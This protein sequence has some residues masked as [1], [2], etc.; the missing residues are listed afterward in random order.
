MFRRKEKRKKKSERVRTKKR[1]IDA[2]DWVE[3][4]VRK[5]SKKNEEER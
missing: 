1:E 5:K 3:D 4:T 2:R